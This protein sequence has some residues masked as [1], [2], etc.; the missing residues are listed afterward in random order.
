[1]R[2]RAADE[3]LRPVEF[4][5]PLRSLAALYGSEISWPA[6]SKL[7]LVEPLS[8]DLDQVY[9]IC[10]CRPW[11]KRRCRPACREL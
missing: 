3:T 2:D 6:P 5:K 9:E 7:E 11:L 8:M 1:M 10:V 4:G